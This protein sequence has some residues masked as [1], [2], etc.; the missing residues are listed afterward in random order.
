MRRRK[1]PWLNHN[2]LMSSRK[3][4]T[5]LSRRRTIRVKHVYVP[6]HGAHLGAHL[7]ELGEDPRLLLRQKI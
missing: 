4:S 7:D 2:V 3:A 1:S 5:V 6:A